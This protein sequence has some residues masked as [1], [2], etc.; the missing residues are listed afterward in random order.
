[1]NRKPP[2]TPAQHREMGKRLID[3]HD[4]LIDLLLVAQDHLPKSKLKPF[5]GAL[6]AIDS[7]RFRMDGEF[8]REH[9]REFNPRAYYPG[10]WQPKRRGGKA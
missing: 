3:V 4:E 1:M 8:A 7:V 6:S 9:P 5:T 2:M 10:G